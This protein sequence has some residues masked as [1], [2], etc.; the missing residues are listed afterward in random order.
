MKQDLLGKNVTG[1]IAS[2]KVR[3]ENKRRAFSLEEVRRI[4]SQCETVGGEWEGL[5]LT[6]IYTGQRRGDICAMT[7]NQI[8]L[9]PKEISFVTSK[10]G[11]RL[12]IRSLATFAVN[13]Y[14][15]PVLRKSNCVIPAVEQ[16][17]IGAK[18]T[19][20]IRQLRTTNPNRRRRIATG[21]LKDNADR[22]RITYTL[23]TLF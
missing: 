8:A 3:G 16:T 2:L 5:V 17:R 6:A 23:H 14:P 13:W 21:F 7:W 1:N 20:G 4:F 9:T 19:V 10:T 22:G 18:S 15:I 11:K 12:G